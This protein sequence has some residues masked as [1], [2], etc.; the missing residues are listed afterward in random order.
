MKLR[1]TIFGT[2]AAVLLAGCA[3]SGKWQSEKIP[4]PRST[5]FDSD[6]FARTAYLDGFR[7][8]YRAEAFGAAGTVDMLSEPYKEARRV[9]YYAGAGQAKA[10]KEA[11]EKSAK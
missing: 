4:Y 3:S 9:G 5:P 6:Q 2:L 11:A 8:G 10:E 1:C 7:T